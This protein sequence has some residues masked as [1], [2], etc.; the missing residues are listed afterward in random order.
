MVV[1]TILGR[2]SE[3]G[4]EPMK[5]GMM[6]C[7]VCHSK[8]VSPSAKTVSRAY[9][10][11]KGRVSSKQRVLNLLLVVGDCFLVG[12]QVIFA[13]EPVKVLLLPYSLSNDNVIIL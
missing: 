11:Y 5:N 12:L 7:S 4:F 3:F 6:E 1:D 8:L 13:S 2:V 9:D 10:Q